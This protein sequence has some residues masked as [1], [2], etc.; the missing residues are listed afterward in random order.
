MK[1]SIKSVQSSFCE[2]PKTAQRQLFEL[3]LPKVQTSN[4]V[5]N[6][7]IF[8]AASLMTEIMRNDTEVTTS[9]LLIPLPKVQCGDL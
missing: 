3:P 1:F 6:S 2:R 8:K 4:L 7:R 9:M 5:L